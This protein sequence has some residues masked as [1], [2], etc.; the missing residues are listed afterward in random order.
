MRVHLPAVLTAVILAAVA[1]AACEAPG[2]DE[3]IGVGDSAAGTGGIG[4]AGRGGAG[5]TANTGGGGSGAAPKCPDALDACDAAAHAC[6]STCV[7]RS[8][9]H[10]GCGQLRARRASFLTPWPTHAPQAPVCSAIAFP[11]GPTATEIPRTDAKQISI[12]RHIAA[13]APTPALPARSARRQIAWRRA[14]RRSRAARG[15]ASTS[16]QRPTT[17]VVARP[18]AAPRPRLYRCARMARAFHR[19]RAPA[20]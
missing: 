5:G 6:S 17:A 10:H 11:V 4:G 15:H 16:C 19:L 13:A 2:T 7:A 1:V 3:H 12:R 20:G 8:D 9:P 14:L 18:P